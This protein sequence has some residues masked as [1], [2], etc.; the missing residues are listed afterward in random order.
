MGLLQDIQ[1]SLLTDKCEISPLL[2]KL[3]LLAARLGSI[4]LEDWVRYEIE[5]YPSAAAL[6]EYRKIGIS[7]RGTFSGPFG[8]G[9]KNAP[10]PIY[11]IEK[12]AGKSWSDYRVR[13]SLA[14]IESL[15]GD[16]RN[17]DG[18]LNIDASNLMLLVQGNIYEDYACN[19]VTG[20]IS[21]ASLVEI[22]NAVKGRILELTIKIEK[23]IPDS[24][25]ISIADNS[26]IIDV[27]KI[28]KV[29][30]ITQNIVYGNVSNT[31][32]N[33]TNQIIKNDVGSLLDFLRSSGIS[34]NDSDEFLQLLT[35]DPIKSEKTVSAKTN[36]WVKD[37]LK[38]G[39]TGAWKIGK[40]IAVEVLTDAAK[41][42]V[43]L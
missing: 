21:K 4:E 3:R 33:Q 39:A 16:S 30:N 28:D 15:L 25:K 23:E 24:R 43:G 10:L 37:K 6:P 19:S 34:K 14:S 18:T 38:A 36:N 5:G 20:T 7:Y 26:D 27:T 32:Y 42:F 1:A 35:S 12:Y 40:E 2:F 31:I 11:L 41:K 29:N 17:G 13:Q 8:S 9:I 22:Q